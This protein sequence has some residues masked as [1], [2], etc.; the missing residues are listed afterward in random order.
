VN[1]E[2]SGNPTI[3][4]PRM[5]HMDT[6]MITPPS[7]GSLPERA[8]GARILIAEDDAVSCEVL[9]TRLR[10]WGYETVIT[11]DGQEAMTVMRSNNAPALA[12]LDWMMPGMDGIEVCRRLR[13]INKAVYIIMLTSLGTKENIFHALEAGADDYLV[14]PFDT[15]ALQSRIQVGLRIIGLQTALADRV[16]ELEAAVAKLQEMQG[17]LQLPI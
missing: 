13:E 4:A 15:F 8:S 3:P 12:V 6:S 14:K 10:Q 7:G 16:K 11:R 9:A 17:R 1:S 2:A 5:I